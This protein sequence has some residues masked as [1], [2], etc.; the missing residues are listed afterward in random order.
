MR[1]IVAGILGV[2]VMNAFAEVSKDAR[3]AIR[4]GAVGRYT[5]R[6]VDEGGSV[7]PNA[8]AHV[9]FR[10]YGRPQDNSDWVVESDSN[11]MFTVEHRFNERFS[12]AFDKNGY[13]HSHDEVNYLAMPELP[14]KDGK[15]QPYDQ[16]RTMVL[17]RI[18]SPGAVGV[19]CEDSHRLR[20]PIW[21]EWIGF[22]FE[23]GDWVPPYGNGKFT[24]VLLRFHSEVR[25]RRVDFSYAMDV[26]FTNN[27]F[28]GAYQMKF[29]ERSDLRT[30]Y[31]A[32]TNR[33]YQS[34]FSFS[35][36]CSPGKA[37]ISNFVDSDS[38]LV[39]RTR[40][41]VDRTGN[42]VGAH[43]GKIC[44]IWRSTHKEM[45]L[46]DGCFNSKENDP[47]IEGDQTLLY[48][49]RNYKK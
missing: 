20:I 15:W 4:N 9:W 29:D 38:Y 3:L 8:R 40:T 21:G 32:D 43:Y 27:P 17:K 46:S 28:G 41:R 35:T 36:E 30:Q 47:N 25:K 26:C 10:S 44:G 39:F 7:V 48:T 34:T 19:F 24:D 49:L 45:L 1:A 16:V 23:L 11:G 31:Q 5:Y 2:V 37:V 42:L 12:V 33:A 6:V 13:Y 18:K 22:D 14:V